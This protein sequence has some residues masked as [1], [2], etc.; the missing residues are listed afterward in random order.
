MPVTGAPKL[1]QSHGKPQPYSGLGHTPASG[2]KSSTSTK[3]K[4]REAGG[5]RMRPE[6]LAQG[7]ASSTFLPT[8]HRVCQGPGEPP[9]TPKP[10]LVPTHASILPGIPP[11]IPAS[12]CSWGMRAGTHPA[13]GAEPPLCHQPC[14]VPSSWGGHWGHRIRKLSGSL[15]DEETPVAP[16][17]TGQGEG[18]TAPPGPA[19]QGGDPQHLPPSPLS[20]VSSPCHHLAASTL[21]PCLSY[22]PQPWCPQAPVSTGVPSLRALVSVSWCPQCPPHAGVPVVSPQSQWCQPYCPPTTLLLPPSRCAPPIPSVPPPQCPHP[23][24]APRPLSNPPHPFPPRCPPPQTRCPQAG[25]R[26]PEP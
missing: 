14:L 12:P 10:S 7:W 4:S 25:A 9:S 13:H 3:A 17:G 11:A 21:Q 23:S 8:K 19:P 5:C 1:T 24:V 18:T 16:T 6:G 2:P 22:R 26:T 15:P 20:L